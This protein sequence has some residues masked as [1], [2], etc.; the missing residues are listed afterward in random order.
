MNALK[1]W[2]QEKRGKRVLRS[3]ENSNIKNKG[4]EQSCCKKAVLFFYPVELP[5]QKE[6]WYL[7]CQINNNFGDSFYAPLLCSYVIH[8]GG[9]A[10]KSLDSICFA[11]FS[12]EI[13]FLTKLPMSRSG[14]I[15]LNASKYVSYAVTK[16]TLALGSFFS[17]C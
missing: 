17:I 9:L 8:L 10:S 7:Q 5:R 2:S 15:S 4:I 1:K 3:N 11:S 14:N 13:G 6:T 12:I 16:N